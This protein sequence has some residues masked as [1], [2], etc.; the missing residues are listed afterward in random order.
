MF[1]WVA[2]CVPFRYQVA[3]V[4]LTFELIAVLFLFVFIA[5]ANADTITISNSSLSTLNTTGISRNNS[6]AYRKR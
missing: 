2:I 6:K 1:A 5:L 3:F 4:M